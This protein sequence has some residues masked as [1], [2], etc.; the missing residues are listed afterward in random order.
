MQLDHLEVFAIVQVKN[1]GINDLN[2]GSAKVLCKNV[3][4]LYLKL[5]LEHDSSHQQYISERAWLCSNKASFVR[6][7]A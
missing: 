2:Q 7:C 3:S 6:R 1:D 4:C 5:S